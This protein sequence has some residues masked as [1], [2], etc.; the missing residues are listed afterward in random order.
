MTPLTPTRFLMVLFSLVALRLPAGKADAPATPIVWDTAIDG[1]QPGFQLTTPGMS[2]N[3]RA[4]FNSR[5][6]YNVLVRNASNQE[7]V[8]ELHANSAPYLIPNDNL[9]EALRAPVLSKRFRALAVT[10]L[11]AASGAYDVKLAPGEAVVVP[12][13]LGLYLGNADPHSFPRVEAVQAGKNWI[14]QPISVRTLTAVER[15]QFERMNATPYAT[16]KVVTI[17]G[18]DGKTSEIS[19][20]VIGAHA[21]GKLLLARIQIEVETHK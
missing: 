1:L 11:S 14:V 9:R 18:R 10:P 21:D 20:P 16:K 7:R 2:T 12:G 8:L 19:A 15:A 5:V 13:E 6:D 17:V 4:P 3:R